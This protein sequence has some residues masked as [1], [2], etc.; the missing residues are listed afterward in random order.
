MMGA[1][2]LLFGLAVSAVLWFAGY[3]TIAVIIILLALF[4]AFIKRGRSFSAPKGTQ[5]LAPITVQA[6][7]WQPP[8]RIPGTTYLSI[9]EGFLEHPKYAHPVRKGLGSAVI[10]NSM[11]AVKEAFE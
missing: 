10:K 5:M 2:T 4:M 6:G 11:R 8:Y 9:G 1:S 7:T 3:R